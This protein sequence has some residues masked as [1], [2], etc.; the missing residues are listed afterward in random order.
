MLER[1]T[2]PPDLE[3]GGLRLYPS[4][5]FLRNLAGNL[6]LQVPKTLSVASKE[7][8][9]DSSFADAEQEAFAFVS[10][11]YTPQKKT[12]L[13]LLCTPHQDAALALRDMRSANPPAVSEQQT[14]ASPPSQAAQE[15][16]EAEPIR[17]KTGNE[18]L[19]R[20]KVDLVRTH[21]QADCRFDIRFGFTCIEQST[22]NSPLECV[23][24]GDTES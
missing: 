12:V 19:L 22:F 5:A 9:T 21:C 17:Q 15:T 16:P 18:A 13:E 2:S 7:V 11:M 3:S 23:C 8:Q 6:G 10:Q 24:P 4:P 14:P 20:R 1:Q